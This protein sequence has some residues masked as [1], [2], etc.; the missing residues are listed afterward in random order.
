MVGGPAAGCVV[1]QLSWCW[2][3]EYPTEQQVSEGEVMVGANPGT[4][5]AAV[6]EEDSL[7]RVITQP[8]VSNL[9]QD[10]AQAALGVQS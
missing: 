1:P 5:S 2:E 10:G 9:E 4:R 7:I 8:E 3:G 6:L